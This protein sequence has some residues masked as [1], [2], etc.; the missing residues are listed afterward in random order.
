MCFHMSEFCDQDVLSRICFDQTLQIQG[1]IEFVESWQVF[2]RI[3]EHLFDFMKIS[4]CHCVVAMNSHS[5]L[6]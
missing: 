1:M 4:S 3:H 6:L 5:F 2:V